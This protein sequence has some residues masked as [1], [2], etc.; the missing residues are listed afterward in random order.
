MSTAVMVP[1]E[2]ERHAVMRN[3][4]DIVDIIFKTAVVLATITV[5]F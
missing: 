4:K 5:L 3:T 2:V 1:Q